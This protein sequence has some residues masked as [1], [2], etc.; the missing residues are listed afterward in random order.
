L[1]KKGLSLALVLVLAASL[2]AG[3]AG[4]Q[5][6]AEE[7]KI[8]NIGPL[9]GDYASYGENVRRG[10]EIAVEEVN[11]NGGIDGKMLKLIAEDTKGVTDDAA[12]AVTKLM[13]QDQVT[14]IVGAV[15]SGEMNTAAP[16]ANDANVV[17]I[18]PSATATGIPDIGEYIFRN[19]LSDDVQGA[20]LA[21]YAITN[22]G[23]AKI[24]ILYA[25]ND[26]G[27]ALKNAVEGKASELASVVAVESYNDGEQDFNAVLTS[28]KS[29]QPDT[30]YIAG[31]YT[32]AAKIAQQA[33]DQGLSVQILGADGFFSTKL[34]ELGGEAVEGAVFT[35]SF[36][37]DDPAEAVQNFVSAYQ[38]KYGEAADMFAAQGYDAMMLVVEALK[39]G[40]TDRAAVRD[41]LAEVKDYPGI[42]GK[43]SFLENGDC[44]KEVMILKVED[45]NF[46]KIR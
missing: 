5:E 46:A 32:E 37:P 22:L 31:Y 16:L 12:R 33:E 1:Q 7:I 20:Q 3:C 2:L 28:I 34:V 42:T 15:L 38:T 10:A 44:E 14:A 18:S 45:G 4:G 9:T 36:Y 13:E 23:A 8:G 30:L 41:A 24:A 6:A 40:G 26:Y 29:K 43:T 21:E 39:V 11:A 25:K 19:C 17:M 35:A 27:E